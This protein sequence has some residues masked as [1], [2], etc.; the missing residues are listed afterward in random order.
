MFRTV[1]STRKPHT[2]GLSQRSEVVEIKALSFCSPRLTINNRIGMEMRYRIPFWDI[3]DRL[4]PE[5]R[6]FGIAFC[7]RCSEGVPGRCLT[8][9]FKPMLFD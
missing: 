7:N 9:E 8:F 6:P 1:F 2:T 5:A 3:I 4:T